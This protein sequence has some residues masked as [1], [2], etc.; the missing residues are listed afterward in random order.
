M[1]KKFRLPIYCKR[2]IGKQHV[3]MSP[4]GDNKGDHGLQREGKKR[5]SGKDSGRGTE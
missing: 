2:R 4:D 5:R 1:K 3:G